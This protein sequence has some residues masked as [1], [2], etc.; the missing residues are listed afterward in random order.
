MI[1]KIAPFLVAIAIAAGG[2]IYSKMS[3][4]N[5][6]ALLA[7]QRETMGD[8]QAT[9]DSSDK[10]ATVSAQNVVSV[11][12]GVDYDRMADDKAVAEELVSM[13]TTWSNWDEYDSARNKLMET[14]GLTE[15]DSFVTTFMPKVGK[16]SPKNPDYNMIDASG[17]NM[18]FD[19]MDQYLVKI[20]GDKYTY[21]SNVTM[22]STYNDRS[23]TSSAMVMYT[24]DGEGKVS[25]LYGSIIR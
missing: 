22:R 10:E 9:I 25:D 24:I 20:D 1:K 19:G 11:L 6:D 7:E 5:Y 12:T 17:W 3:S 14:Y 13:V 23:A 8:L 4:S 15:E 2:V 21:L 18:K 16:G